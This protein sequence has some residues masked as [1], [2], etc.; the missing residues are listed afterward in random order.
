MGQLLRPVHEFYRSVLAPVLYVSGLSAL[1]ILLVLSISIV[2][3]DT[4]YA[5]TENDTPKNSTASEDINSNSDRKNPDNT[6]AQH[7]LSETDADSTQIVKI[8]MIHIPETLD[9]RYVDNVY[10]IRILN[11]IYE[12]LLTTAADGTIIPG[13]AESWDILDNG[14]TYVFYLRENAYWSDGN[15][16]VANDFVATFRRLFNTGENTTY[17]YSSIIGSPQKNSDPT[18]TNQFGVKALNPKQLEIKLHRPNSLMLKMLSLYNSFPI[19]SHIYQNYDDTFSVNSEVTNGAYQINKEIKSEDK[20]KLYLIR[21]PH[22]W[23]TRNV[24]IDKVKYVSIADKSNLAR[25]MLKHELD[26]VYHFQPYQLNV[27]AKKVPSYVRN[28]PQLHGYYYLINH[29]KRKLGDIR[30]RE[31]LTRAINRKLL[32]SATSAPDI[33]PLYNLVP[34]IGNY[35]GAPDI[36][37]YNLKM[38][39]SLMK[40][41]GY[42]AEHPLTLKLISFDNNYDRNVATFISRSWK[43]I[44]IKLDMHFMP[45]DKLDLAITNGDFDISRFSWLADYN[46]PSQF[47]TYYISD[48]EYNYGQW[49]NSQFDKIMHLSFSKFDTEERFRLLIDAEILANHSISAI[50]IYSSKLFSMVNP[51]LDGWVDNL[52]NTHLARWLSFSP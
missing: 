23:D 22:F 5:E 16:V 41:S 30:I 51:K 33:Q 31:A 47:L 9:P 1:M 34:P 40:S 12:G 26:V 21:N 3:S 8:G 18:N 48:N 42:S 50:P 39:K 36:H 38:A 43:N 10:Q 13:V 49:S 19:P 25:V 28:V 29:S 52:T 45:Y 4:V 37:E 20:T 35:K 32:P 46:D 24:K 6:P 2:S 17:N 7:V 14:L 15:P 11:D 27:L 44:Y